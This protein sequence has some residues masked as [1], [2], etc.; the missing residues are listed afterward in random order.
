MTLGPEHKILSP[1]SPDD[2]AVLARTG[3]DKVYFVNLLVSRQA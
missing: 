2:Q 3:G 1:V